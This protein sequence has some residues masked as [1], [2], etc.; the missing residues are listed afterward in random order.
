L[1]PRWQRLIDAPL[2]LLYCWPLPRLLLLLLLL[3]ADKATCAPRHRRLLWPRWQR[4][5]AALLLLLCCW[6]LPLLLPLLLLAAMASKAGCQGLFKAAAACVV[7][8][9]AHFNSN[10][11]VRLLRRCAQ[12]LPGH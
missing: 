8:A 5:S 2:L 3:L 1:W 9:A 6:L 7:P 12:V 4:P 11:V 10:P